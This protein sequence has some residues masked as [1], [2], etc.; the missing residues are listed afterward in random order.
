MSAKKPSGVAVPKNKNPRRDLTPKAPVK[1]DASTAKGKRP[2]GEALTPAEKRLLEDERERKATEQVEAEP[3]HVQMVGRGE[4]EATAKTEPATNGQAATTEADEPTTDAPA[5]EGQE[6]QEGAV[7]APVEDAPATSTEESPPAQLPAVPETE[8]V[9][10]SEVQRMRRDS[11]IRQVDERKEAV[12][13]TARALYHLRAEKLYLETHSSFEAFVEARWDFGRSWAFSLTNA[14]GVMVRLE[15][16]GVVHLPQSTKV[17]LE[18]DKVAAPED[19]AYVFQTAYQLAQE[20]GKTT[21]AASDVRK[22]AE[23]TGKLVTRGVGRPRKD[24][25]RNDTATPVSEDQRRL[26]AAHANGSIPKGATVEVTFTDETAPPVAP[27]D[28]SDDEF[29]ES[30]DPIRDRLTVRT[31]ALFDSQAL[32]YRAILEAKMAFLE[33][34]VGPACEKARK[35]ANL[36]RGEAGPYLGLIRWALKLA[37]PSQ[38]KVCE[39]CKGAGEMGK[40][41]GGCLD[42]KR[43][44]FH[45]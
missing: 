26:H 36:A 7:E 45:I 34:T 14:T 30:L 6:G 19:Q 18:L 42:C 29:L 38:W 32:G 28:Q 40:G 37:H 21:P 22:A 16:A 11:L 27:A 1:G 12:Y 13:E 41:K 17:A 23:S 20:Q 39:T 25:T 8:L 44:G 35:A 9:V 3:T 4:R 31:R 43:D 5:T 10:L 24:G 15:E 33:D 2:K